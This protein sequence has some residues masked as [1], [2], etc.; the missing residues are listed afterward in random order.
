MII[1]IGFIYFSLSIFFLFLSWEK[2][3]E[4]NKKKK[5]KRSDGFDGSHI[6]YIEIE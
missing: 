6:L 1:I 4:E 5:I 3:I 2:N